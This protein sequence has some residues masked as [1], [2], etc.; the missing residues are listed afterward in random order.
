LSAI[1]RAQAG[2]I[3]IGTLTPLTGSGGQYGPG[4][5]NVVKAV[6]DVWVEQAAPS[7]S[8]EAQQE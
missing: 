1:V 4:M 6:A 8:G 5:A 3:R 7:P 2:P